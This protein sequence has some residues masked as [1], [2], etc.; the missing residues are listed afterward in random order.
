MVKTIMS[1]L[2]QSTKL[3]QPWRVVRFHALGALG[4][5]G[6]AVRKPVDQ[7]YKQGL[8]NA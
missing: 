8:V 2:K 7:E 4:A 5:L 3:K 6:A 1:K